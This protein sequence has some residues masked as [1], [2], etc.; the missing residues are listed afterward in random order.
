[1][2]VLISELASGVRVVATDIDGTLTD[3]GMYYTDS[4]STFKRFHVRDGLAVKLLQ[5]AGFEVVWISSDSSPVIR[6]RAERLGVD[7]CYVSVT[8]KT[9]VMM[10]VCEELGESAERV[11]FLGD[12]LQDLTVM[13]FVGYPAA[14]ADAHEEVRRIAEY[15]CVTP[16]G[17]GAFREF[18]EHL[19]QA[20]GED[21]L[22][23]WER[24]IKH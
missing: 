12:D 14:V 11:A 10:K 20:R 5:A 4:G 2:S 17:K 3:G 23:V 22:D 1:M 7:R 15:E 18:A 21:L 6:K 8:D 24:S 19:I 13:K 9:S 16:G